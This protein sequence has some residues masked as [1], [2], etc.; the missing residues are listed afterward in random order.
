MI[1]Y[2]MFHKKGYLGN[3]LRILTR[4]IYNDV[5]TIFLKILVEFFWG[6][7]YFGQI[8]FGSNKI[9]VGIFFWS[10][11]FVGQKNLR[12]KFFG[13]KKNLVKKNWVNFLG[14]KKFG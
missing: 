5:K 11:I 1:I 3:L 12:Q 6:K 14:Q 2:R 9:R 8:F 4:L 10:E 13:S 7:K